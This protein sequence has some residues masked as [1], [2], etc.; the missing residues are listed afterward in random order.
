MQMIILSIH[1]LVSVCL[2]GLVL[3]QRSEGGALGI[4]GGGGGALMSG[5]GASD[6]LANLTSIAG[7]LFLGVSLLLTW[8]S[9]AGDGGA[10]SVFDN[11]PAA[12][13]APATTAPTETA[14]APAPAEESAPDP[15]QS[16]LPTTNELAAAIIPGPAPA[17]AAPP[18]STRAAPIENRATTQPA[19]TRTTPPPATTQQGAATQPATTQPRATTQPATQRATAPAT[20]NNQSAAAT[21]PA[22]TGAP[23]GAV[24][25]V[26]LTEPATPE[27]VNPNGGVAAVRRER[28]GPDQ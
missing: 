20:T 9:G 21:N 16:S 3:L 10:R 18:P 4:G 11:A 13:T 17:A 25:G 12:I 23:Q 24:S 27:S 14:P 15:T 26:T 1:L 2:I 22:R 5:R 7:A 19:S 28:A 6:A 8:L